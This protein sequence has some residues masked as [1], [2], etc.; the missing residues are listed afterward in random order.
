MK[1]IVAALFAIACAAPAWTQDKEPAPKQDGE[2]KAPPKD[3]GDPVKKPGGQ[4]D[5]GK[6]PKKGAVED[7]S[8]SVG[9]VD[10]NGDGR[11]S[12]SELKAAMGKLYPKKDGGSKDGGDV[13]KPVNKDGA[14]KDPPKDGGKKDFPKQTEGEKNAEKDKNEGSKDGGDV[15]KPASKDGQK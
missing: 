6:V 3:G 7:P 9:E 1:L 13:K 2:K 15:K 5:G 8:L 10:T 11:I 12:A 14:P 4:D